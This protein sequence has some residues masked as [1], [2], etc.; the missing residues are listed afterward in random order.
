[1]IRASPCDFYLRYLVTHPDR[2]GDHQ[3]RNLVKLQKLDFLGM[4][5]LGRLRA[6]CTPP[7]PF[8]PDDKCHHLSQRF[9]TKE[10]IHG[11]YHPDDD[12]VIAIQL[13]DHP[14]GKELTEQMLVTGAETVWICAMLKRVQF[15]ATPR[16]IELYQHFYFNTKL[17]DATEL[18]AILMMR[19][20]VEV[21]QGDS[22]AKNYAL[23]YASAS[24]ADIASLTASSSLSP[25]AR[26]LN[27]MKMGIMPSGVQLSKIATVARM[28]SIVRAAESSLLGHPEK[29]RDFALAGKILTELMESVGDVS[30]DLQKGMQNMLLDTDAS[31]VPSMD[32]LTN[33]NVAV[34]LLPQAT[35]EEEGEADHA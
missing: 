7:T 31:E 23:S 33:G 8:Y 13:L 28:A 5:H 27:M 35:G 14:R 6:E 3:I 32:E 34:D 4:E 22:D 18:R 19:S 25:F 12:G 20:Q 1:M 24:K 17:V 26:V 29:A 11:L 15:S 10:R 21:N 2:Y 9:L 30:G 16:S